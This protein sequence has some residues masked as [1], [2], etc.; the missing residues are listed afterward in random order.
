MNLFWSDEPILW[1]FQMDS[2]GLIHWL[3][4]LIGI[5]ALEAL[6]LIP[7]ARIL[8]RIGRTGWWSILAIFPIANVI[9]LWALAFT[10]W[11]EFDRPNPIG[12]E[13]PREG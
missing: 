2:A 8:R 5:S 3:V 13:S 9:G 4:V 1:I 11:P 10:Q 6:V 12:Q 7:V